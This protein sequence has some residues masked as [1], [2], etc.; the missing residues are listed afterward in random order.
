MSKITHIGVVINKSKDKV[1]VQVNDL[2]CSSCGLKNACGNGGD[3]QKLFEIPV[4]ES[5]SNGEEVSLEMSEELGLKAM[6]L[7][8]FFPFLVLIIGIMIGLHFFNEL[9]A[10]LI[11]IILIGIYYALIRKNENS[12]AKTIQ[13]KILK[14]TKNE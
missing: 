2:S 13:L 5:F 4:K 3:E 11:G 7:A 8:F 12:I 1:L 14:T 10:S 9:I 6:L